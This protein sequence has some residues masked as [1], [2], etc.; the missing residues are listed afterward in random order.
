M[1]LLKY[2]DLHLVVEKN[3]S[4]ID[5]EELASQTKAQQR[6]AALFAALN[7]CIIRFGTHINR[8]YVLRIQSEVEDD[9][10]TEEVRRKSQS[11][12]IGSTTKIYSTAVWFN[13]KSPQPFSTRLRYFR[14]MLFPKPEFLRTRYHP[15]PEWLWP[16]YYLARFLAGGR[17]W[18]ALAEDAACP[19]KMYETFPEIDLPCNKL[20]FQSLVGG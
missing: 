10:I 4:Q 16:L 2:Y 1:G 8:D 15:K 7:G 18:L 12:A 17:L 6:S 13:L 20:R 5:W 9:L 19:L 14:E 11:G 3:E